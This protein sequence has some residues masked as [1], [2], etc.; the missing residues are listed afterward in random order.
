MCRYGSCQFSRG[1]RVGSGEMQDEPMPGRGNGEAVRPHVE[2]MF[3][4]ILDFQCQKG[5]DKYRTDLETFNGRD[6][7]NDALA[8]LVD[9]FQYVVQAKLENDQLRKAL[10]L[11]MAECRE[12]R[13]LDEQAGQAAVE[14]IRLAVPA[15]EALVNTSILQRVTLMDTHQGQDSV[16]WPWT[17]AIETAEAVLGRKG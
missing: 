10:R 11:S 6:A 4:N 13:K 8:E 12:L 3:Q 9:A 17:K 2:R 1:A 14:W 7:L 15:L 5:R 16:F